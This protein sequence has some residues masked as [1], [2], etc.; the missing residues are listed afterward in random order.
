MESDLPFQSCDQEVSPDLAGMRLDHVLRRLV[1]E[2][3]RTRLQELVRDGG[4]RVDGEVV[5]SCSLHLEAG[6]RIELRAMPRSSI[7]TGGPDGENLRVVYEDEDLAVIDK[8]AGMVCH[9]SSTVQGGTVSERAVER[10]GELPTAQG[11]DRPG[12]VHRLDANTTG[13]MVIA[14]SESA[15]EGLMLQFRERE[16]EKVYL[17]IVHGEP[18]FDSD[19]IEAEIGRSAKRSDR[20]SAVPKGEGQEAETYYE[21]L[22]RARGFGVLDCRPKTGRTHQ[23]RVHLSSIDLP[24]IGD[25]IYRGRR[26]LALKFPRE[27]PPISRQALHAR[28]LA[29]RHPRSGERVLF[30]S[31]PPEDLRSFLDW[32]GFEGG[33]ESGSPE[34]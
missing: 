24:I 31:G 5:L 10:W 26:G 23:I 3:S 1:P 20:M 25:T 11:K 12:I 22:L 32:L 27:A 7:R 34:R 29:F 17:A 4:V 8:P 18:R 33:E 30:E 21:T 9:P 14:R 2:V 16:V 15:A 19:W 13:L 6:A 28:S